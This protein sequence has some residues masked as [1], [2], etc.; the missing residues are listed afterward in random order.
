M[1]ADFPQEHPQSDALK[2]QNQ[3]LMQ[4][5]AVQGFPTVV[6]V[7]ADGSQKGSEGY[8]PGG[9]QSWIDAITSDAHIR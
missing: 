6:V 9:A 3:Q 4:K 7:A 8:E 1:T 2:Q 5:Y